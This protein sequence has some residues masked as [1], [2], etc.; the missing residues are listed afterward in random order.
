VADD[1]ID[2]RR[3]G[4]LARS[5]AERGMRRR[6]GGAARDRRFAIDHRELGT[7]DLRFAR[8][9]G[10]QR[11]EVCAIAVEPGQNSGSFL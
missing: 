4:E 11:F 6:V 8:G 5:A 3:T 10:A 9:R 2:P 7:V 1:A